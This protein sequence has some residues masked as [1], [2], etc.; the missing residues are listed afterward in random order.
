[1][2]MLKKENKWNDGFAANAVWQDFRSSQYNPY[3]TSNGGTVLS[4]YIGNSNKNTLPQYLTAVSFTDT[5][6]TKNRSNS[7]MMHPFGTFARPPSANKRVKR[8][9]RRGSKVSSRS[10]SSS[11]AKS[12]KKFKIAIRTEPV[13]RLEEN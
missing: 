9:S 5:S 8:L 1:M 6:P 4:P 10:R 12:S 2:R 11:L 7:V 13:S 3:E